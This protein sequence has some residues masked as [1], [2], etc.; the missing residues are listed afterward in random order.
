MMWNLAEWMLDGAIPP[1]DKL[2]AELHAPRWSAL[3]DNRMKATSKDDLRD[4]LNRSPDR[5]DAL[6]L[7]V[8]PRPDWLTEADEAGASPAASTAIDVYDGRETGRGGPLDPFAGGLDPY[9]GGL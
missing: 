9:G 6:C 1:D 2:Q 7:A 8:Q 5:C 3:S 4:I